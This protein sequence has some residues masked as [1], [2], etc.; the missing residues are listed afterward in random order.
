MTLCLQNILDIIV[1]VP[2]F[3]VLLHNVYLKVA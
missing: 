1:Q 2:D 3:Q